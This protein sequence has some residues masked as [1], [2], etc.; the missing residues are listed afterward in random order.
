M[1]QT[2][3]QTTPLTANAKDSKPVTG[4]ERRWTAGTD[5]SHNL[6]LVWPKDYLRSAAKLCFCFS[7]LFN[8]PTSWSYWDQC[9]YHEFFEGRLKKKKN[10]HETQSGNQFALIFFMLRVP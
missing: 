8:N 5:V 3:V 1:Q 4:R 6:M 7:A 10:A 9:V 2:K